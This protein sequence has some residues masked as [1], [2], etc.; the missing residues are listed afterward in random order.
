M[1]KSLAY[2]VILILIGIS[3]GASTQSLGAVAPLVKSIPYGDKLIHFTLIGSLAYVVNFLLNFKRFTFLNKKWLLGTTV[4]LIIMTLEEFSQK[5]LPNRDFELLD[6]TANS[7]GIF[8]AT[9]VILIQ[10]KQKTP[11]SMPNNLAK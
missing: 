4:I 9:L 6:L 2:L 3:I 1:Q 11:E 5:F 10:Q 8:A 7:L